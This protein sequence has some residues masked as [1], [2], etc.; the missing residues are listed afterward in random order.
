MPQPDSRRPDACL[1]EALCIHVRPADVC[2][3]DACPIDVCLT[4]ARPTDACLAD[5]SVREEIRIQHEIGF[6][7]SAG[8]VQGDA[9]CP[10]DGRDVANERL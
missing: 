1:P 3:T 9:H 8:C 6:V 10:A 4:D 5:R 7:R 2:Q